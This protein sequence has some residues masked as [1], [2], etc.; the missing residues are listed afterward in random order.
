MGLSL[1]QGRCPDPTALQHEH[2]DILSYGPSSLHLVVSLPCSCRG[3][4]PVYL[5]L[6]GSLHLSFSSGSS[7][8]V[9]T[10]VSLSSLHFC[11]IPNLLAHPDT[12]C[13]RVDV[14]LYGS[15]YH[16]SHSEMV[17][18]SLLFKAS[19]DCHLGSS[20]GRKDFVGQCIE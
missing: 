2:L 16:W 20:I 17:P 1:P 7:C 11:S 18:S 8:V 10:I 3:E 5:T 4:V 13:P 9:A 12:P 6:S 14:Y 19:A 15:P